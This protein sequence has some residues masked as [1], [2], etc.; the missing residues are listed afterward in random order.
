MKC[1]LYNKIDCYKKS[2]MM[3][4]K[5]VYQSAMINLYAMNYKDFELEFD[6]VNLEDEFVQIQN[7]LKIFV[8]PQDFVK[9]FY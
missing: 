5:K 8:I 7:D 1:K 2:V 3:N 9:E 6:V 4:N